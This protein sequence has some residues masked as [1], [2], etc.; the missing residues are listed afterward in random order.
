MIAASLAV[1]LMV[2]VLQH[3]EGKNAPAYIR[4]EYEEDLND[5]DDDQ[6]LLGI[7]PH[8]IR[9][10][11]SQFAQVLPTCLCYNHCTACSDR[12]INLYRNEGIE[13]LIKVFNDCNY[14]EECSGLKELHEQ[15]D[16]NDVLE[17]SDDD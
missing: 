7:I 2:S 5:D 6:K 4:P 8:Q 11:L 16:L 13:F 10:F 17:L 12:I 1:E 9:G 3:P 14:L 15:T